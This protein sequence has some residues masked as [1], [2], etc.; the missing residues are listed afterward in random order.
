[1]DI[2]VDTEILA[3][4]SINKVKNASDMMMISKDKKV[5]KLH[6]QCVSTMVLKV[7]PWK[8]YCVTIR[9]DSK[10]IYQNNML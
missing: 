1:M 4:K 8:N 3:V 5:T 7:Y 10:K 6:V 9:M 2:N